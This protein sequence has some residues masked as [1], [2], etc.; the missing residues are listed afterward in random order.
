MIQ[1]ISCKGYY[2]TVDLHICK[3]M[4]LLNIFQFTQ[5]WFFCRVQFTQNSASFRV[6][7]KQD[8]ASFRF[9]L[10]YIYFFFFIVLFIQVSVH[11][12]ILVTTILIT[13][14]TSRSQSINKRQQLRLGHT[15]ISHQTNI[16][17]ACKRLKSLVSNHH[18]KRKI[19]YAVCDFST[20]PIAS[21]E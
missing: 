20:G 4:F 21:N 5:N 10:T 16:Y 6:Q 19:I 14:L 18:L 2:Y 12:L 11:I 13:T 9:P 7:F 15:R 8:S 3:L 1:L 17:I